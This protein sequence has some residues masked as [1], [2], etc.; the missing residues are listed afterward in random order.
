MDNVPLPVQ[1]EE[2]RAEIETGEATLGEY[3]ETAED[4]SKFHNGTFCHWH[5]Y[6]A[7]GVAT[8]T[9]DFHMQS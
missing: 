8:W 1:N 5:I 4:P 9:C 7:A 2:A 6:I 3:L